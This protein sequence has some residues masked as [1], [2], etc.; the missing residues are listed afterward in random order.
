MRFADSELTLE[1]LNGEYRR[2]I[3]AT[4]EM[5]AEYLCV[6]LLNT[7]RILFQYIDTVLEPVDYVQS[8]ISNIPEMALEYLVYVLENKENMLVHMV[9]VPGRETCYDI[10]YEC[11][12]SDNE[13]ISLLKWA[14]NHNDC[15][16][17]E[18]KYTEIINGHQVCAGS[19]E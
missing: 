19:E 15:A 17:F 2:Y 11:D 9:F 16:A 14:L 1:L 4:D 5:R 18:Y 7:N 10:Y 12:C 8:V 6:G 3:N 13:T